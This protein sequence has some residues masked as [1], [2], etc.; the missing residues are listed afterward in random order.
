MVR[1]NGRA[2]EIA[3]NIIG[4]PENLKA[5]TKNYV[6]RDNSFYRDAKYSNVFTEIR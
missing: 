6:K 1:K 4:K 2:K 3:Y 5:H